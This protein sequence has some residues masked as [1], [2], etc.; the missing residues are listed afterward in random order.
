MN[1]HIH[2]RRS[3]IEQPAGLD[4]LEAFVHQ[5]GGIDGDA[6]AHLPCWMI[7]GLRR[8]HKSQIARR[9]IAERT[10]RGGEDQLGDLRPI[11]RPQALMRPVVFAVHRQ[12]FRSVLADRLHHQAAAGNQDFLIGQSDA[13]AE[14]DRFVGG[15]Q[16]GDPHDRGDHGIDL[17][18]PHRFHPRRVAPSQF[19]PLGSRQAGLQSGILS[20]GP[21]RR[22]SRPP[23]VSGG[24]P[25]SER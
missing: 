22:R 8:R 9:G 3:E 14:A 20:D 11:A 25:G 13:F 6:V 2:L 4:H 5:S 17:G 7:Q 1:H 10:A 15:F 24:I 18:R 23:R 21:A 16:A 19:R 12:Q